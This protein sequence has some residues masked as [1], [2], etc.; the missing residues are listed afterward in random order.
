LLNF[1]VLKYSI[2]R[3]LNFEGPRGLPVELPMCH[4]KGTHYLVGSTR[5]HTRHCW[6]RKA[7]IS[8]LLNFKVLKYSISRLLNFEGPRGLL[9]D[10]PMC[11]VKGTHYLVGSTRKQT[12]YCWARKDSISPLLNF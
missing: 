9:V 11:H 3:L 7:P 5:Q 4:V 2:S 1:K 10:L 12:R 6:A 8:R